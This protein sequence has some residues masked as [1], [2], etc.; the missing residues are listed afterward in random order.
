MAGNF[1][2]LN[3]NGIKGKWAELSNFVIKHDILCFS[4]TK[5]N[6]SDFLPDVK[7]YLK[8]RKD[9]KTVLKRMVED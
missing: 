7:G 6:T 8:V 9:K 3:C 4:E 2:Y 1:S 5:L